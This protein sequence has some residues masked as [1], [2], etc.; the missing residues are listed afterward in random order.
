MNELSYV[1]VAEAIP[2]PGLRVAFTQNFPGPWG[3]G[4][5]GILEHKQIAFIAVIQEPGGTNEDLLRWTGQSSAPVAVLDDEKPRALWSE[6]I[7]LAER[8]APDR[9]LIPKDAEQR[10]EMF[11][12]CHELSGEDGLGWSLRLMM[13]EGRRGTAT[14]PNPALVKKYDSGASF[15]HAVARTNAV[16]AML[17]RRLKAQKANGGDFLVGDRVS[18]ADFYWA[19]FSHMLRGFP[20]A[21]CEMP[22]FYR[23]LGDL[24]CPHLEPLD[25]ILFEHRDRMLSR[26]FRTPMKF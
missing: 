21:V 18:A 23:A 26:Y 8:L 12:L 5:R 7:L 16:L 6:I 1:S 4:V 17:T 19:G 13:F 20:E 22:D 10:M 14:P 3:V 9:P 15:A 25:E 2:L 24:V 11:G